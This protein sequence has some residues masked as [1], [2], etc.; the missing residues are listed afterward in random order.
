MLC[1]LSFF[2]VVSL[3]AAAEKQFLEHPLDVWQESVLKT[4]NEMRMTKPEFFQELHSHVPSPYT[5]ALKKT[6]KEWASYVLMISAILHLN[7]QTIQITLTT[8]DGAAF[9][10]LEFNLE[11]SSIVMHSDLLPRDKRTETVMINDETFERMEDFYCTIVMN[12]HQWQI[13]YD[14][15]WYIGRLEP[16]PEI[17]LIERV[18]LS[19]DYRSATI[20][21]TTPFGNEK[22]DGWLEKAP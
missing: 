11:S 18:E 17:T 2:L 15:R 19:G 6:L 1:G 21:L 13:Y 8:R 5:F 12:V 3:S 22:I 14:G 10:R 9:F 7:A 16:P 4:L 20:A